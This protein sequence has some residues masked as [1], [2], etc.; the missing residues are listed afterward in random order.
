MSFTTQR[1]RALRLAR[2]QALTSR[3][4]TALTPRRTYASQPTPP[5]SRSSNTTWLV[6]TAALGIPAAYYLLQGNSSRGSG[7][8]PPS[9]QDQPASRKEPS[10]PG[11]MSSKQEGLDNADTANP[12]VNEPGKSVKGEGETDSAKVK[13]TVNPSRPQQ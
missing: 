6:I 9:K 1:L 4:R 5:E 12:Y 8:T 11:T 2:P 7:T 13:G 3:T 10:S